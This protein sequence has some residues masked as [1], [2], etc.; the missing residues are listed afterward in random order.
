LTASGIEGGGAVEDNVDSRCESQ[1][2]MWQT[3]LNIPALSR[4]EGPAKGSDSDWHKVLNSI[5]STE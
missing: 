4:H 5:H 3:A 1:L 2:R